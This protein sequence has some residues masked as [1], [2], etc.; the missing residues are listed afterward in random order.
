MSYNKEIIQ[1]MTAL[2]SFKILSDYKMVRYKLKLNTRLERTKLVKA[3]L[4]VLDLEN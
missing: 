2:N 3:K 1:A 4:S